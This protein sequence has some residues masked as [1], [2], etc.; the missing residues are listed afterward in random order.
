[1][2]EVLMNTLKWSAVVGLAALI[3]TCLKPLLDKR[4]SAKWRRVAW[5]V[6]AVLL[7]LAPVRWDKFLPHTAI[8]AIEPPVVIEAPKLEVA[9]QPQAGL[10]LQRPAAAAIRYNR[11]PQPIVPLDQVLT[12]LW[13]TV[14]GLFLL[15]R[16]LGS[17]R[18]TRRTWRWSRPPVDGTRD[19]YAAVCRE[20]GLAKAPPLAVS[21]AV[22]SPM[23]VGLFRP[24]LFLPGEDYTSQS[25]AFILRH[26]LT[27]WRRGD[28]WYKLI[29]LAA[30]ALHWFNPLVLLLRRE[31]DQDLELTCDDTVLAGA[32]M[33]TRR[34]YSEALLSSIRP[35]RGQAAMST[36]FYGGKGAMK[37]RFRN[38]LGKRGRKRGLAVLAAA[39]LSV[40]AAAWA[41]GVRANGVLS[42]EEL[43]EWQAR[44]DGPELQP[45]IARM[46]ADPAL[47][48]PEVFQAVPEPPVRA[49]A[50]SGTRKGN[51]V[52]LELEGDF[53][54][55]LTQGTLTL[56]DGAPVSFTTP[57]YSFVEEEAAKAMN[58]AAE[59]YIKQAAE[60]DAI[61]VPLE[62]RERYLTELVCRESKTFDGIRYYVWEVNW[63]MRPSS[64]DGAMLAG[65]SSSQY[66]WLTEM[67]SDGTPF[68]I[69]SVDGNGVPVL[70]EQLWSMNAT[71]TN[72]GWTWEEYLYCAIHMGLEGLE[73]GV[74]G[75]WP[76]P[77]GEF[78]DAFQ[79][80][81]AAWATDWQE[82]VSTY[83]NR[84]YGFN[85][86]DVS[87]NARTFTADE[88]R[89]GHTQAIL[90][91]TGVGGQPVRLLLAEI[92]Y[93]W[94]SES[95]VLH[96]WQVC[97]ERWEG[98]APEPVDPADVP[99]LDAPD[100]SDGSLTIIGKPAVIDPETGDLIFA[101]EVPEI[102]GELL[103][104]PPTPEPAPD[105]RTPA[106]AEGELGEG[107]ASGGPEGGDGIYAAAVID[108]EFVPIPAVGLPPTPPAIGDFDGDGVRDE[109]IWINGQHHRVIFDPET[110][111]IRYDPEAPAVWNTVTTT[112]PGDEAP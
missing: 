37:E 27:H 1:M 106:D 36:H 38:I 72:L 112:P 89:N 88:Y 9:V 76:Q 60:N 13:L 62:F 104:H 5:L 87:T 15:W 101:P 23:L 61:A 8:E 20:M 39:V 25:L 93:S 82:T 21:S 65:G 85:T 11:A 57:F 17:W 44:L 26:E 109:D 10:T 73:N 64:L 42:A 41:F 70:E 67:T 108:G 100:D 107:S 103:N 99:Y 78:L 33:E 55:G 43:A 18:F 91:A 49:E 69:F 110:Q 80:G 95:T 75:G 24:R 45:Y 51:T 94:Y 58:E 92:A 83:L 98:K 52:T 68:L 54:N 16:L 32:D 19:I 7:L 22:D 111:E 63:R 30:G 77:G 6:M 74:Q 46:Y 50:V 90:A 12:A 48:P 34:A 53:S 66:G 29:L 14:G 35:R 84:R 40:L 28:L 81:G 105:S 71:V 47:Y 79:N 102:G 3:L 96:F 56:A 4:Y 86:H 97:G 2:M 31:A 59:G